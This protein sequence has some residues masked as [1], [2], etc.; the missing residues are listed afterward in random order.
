M[1]SAMSPNAVLTLANKT[2]LTKLPDG[3]LHPNVLRRARSVSSLTYSVF[4]KPWLRHFRKK[5]IHVTPA[6]S[7]D[8]CSN[9]LT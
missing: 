5:K 2:A 3:R 7:L 1:G 6:N 4:R 9:A 8:S